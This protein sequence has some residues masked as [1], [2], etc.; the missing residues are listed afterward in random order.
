MSTI[1][2][3]L[4]S[5]NGW[6][7][8][9]WDSRTKKMGLYTKDT[10]TEIVPCVFDSVHTHLYDNH[11]QLKIKGIVFDLSL[12]HPVTGV[13]YDWFSFEDSSWFKFGEDGLYTITPMTFT[14]TIELNL[15]D[16]PV[17]DTE[18]KSTVFKEVCS[19]L[20]Q[21]HR[22]TKSEFE[23]IKAMAIHR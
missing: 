21:C 16:N 3:N 14:D 11:A 13:N 19:V 10:K 17:V 20:N 2:F 23:R 9:A 5:N 15:R 4:K 18:A 12:L 6:C 22:C 8:C 1:E 7:V